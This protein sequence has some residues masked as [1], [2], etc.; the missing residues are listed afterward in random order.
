MTKTTG[1]ANAAT[2]SGAISQ[3]KQFDTAGNLVAESASCC[4]LKTYDYTI[5]TQ[6]A[7]PT[8]QTR[9]SSDPNS[10]V[11]NTTSAVY[12]FYNGLVKQTTDPNGRTSTVSYNSANLRLLLTTSSTGAYS[13]TIYDEAAMT[14]TDLTYAAESTLAGKS[15]TYLNG[16]GKVKRQE[17]VGPNQV[18]DIVETT[19]NNLGQVWKQSNSYRTIADRWWTETVYD[20]QGRR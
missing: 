6:F 3:T 16:I 18:T 19:Y 20:I 14:V 12:D 1:Y 5:A 2:P 7:Y 8:T 15:I 4:Q 11:R 13:Q 10:T 9:G 17:S